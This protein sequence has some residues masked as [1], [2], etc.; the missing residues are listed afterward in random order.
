MRS[1]FLGTFPSRYHYPVAGR[2][3]HPVGKKVRRG[4]L[5]AGAVGLGWALIRRSGAFRVEVAGDS[6]RPTLE[7]G[8]FLVASR[9]GR[10]HRGD[11]VVIR[12]PERPIEVVKRLV[13]VPGDRVEAEGG[14]I[15]VNGAEVWEPYASGVGPSGSWDLGPD[16]YVVLGDNRDRSSDSRAFGPVDRASIVGVVRF[17]YWPRAGRVR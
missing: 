3:A 14:R 11:V 6:M 10:L 1:P 5:A 15:S 12:R 2:Y 16:Q 4:L 8:Q 17:R 7:P 9:P 13:G